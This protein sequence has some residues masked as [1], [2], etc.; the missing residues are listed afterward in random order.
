[1]SARAYQF[2]ADIVF[3]TVTG[4]PD[5]ERIRDEAYQQAMTG[6]DCAFWPTN[7]WRTAVDS[8]VFDN[9]QFIALFNATKQACSL[10]GATDE[11]RWRMV[12]RAVEAEARKYADYCAE[13][14]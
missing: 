2:M 8:P 14:A 5:R 1:M 6:A 7:Q 3:Q 4:K 11:Q 12:H 13:K 9:E 10:I